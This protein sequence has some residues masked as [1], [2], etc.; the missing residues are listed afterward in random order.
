VSDPMRGKYCRKN[1]FL[2]E[3]NKAQDRLKPLGGKVEPGTAD[4]EA[5]IFSMP[6][7][8]LIFY[9]HRTTANNQHIR[10]R[11]CNG[12]DPK[13]LRK[14]ILALAENT[15]TFQFPMDKALHREAV[16]VAIEKEVG[17]MMRRAK[18]RVKA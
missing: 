16:G 7:L 1:T 11:A 4:Y 12:A 14:A 3:F 6:G 2:E 13:L 5:F 15:C 9:P 10:V 17:E 18:T 8:K